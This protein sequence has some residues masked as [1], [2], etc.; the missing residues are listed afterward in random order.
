[1]A[2]KLLLWYGRLTFMKKSILLLPLSQR[3]IASNRLKGAYCLRLRYY[4][5]LNIMNTYGS[6][7]LGTPRIWVGDSHKRW[8]SI[9]RWTD[10]VP[11]RSSISRKLWQ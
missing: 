9:E 8:S 5:D 10:V 2:R 11:Q 1:M 7:C 4:A 3:V 6:G